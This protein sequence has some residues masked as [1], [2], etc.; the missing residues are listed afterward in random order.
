MIY[1]PNEGKIISNCRVINEISQI[2]YHLRNLFILRRRISK[3]AP[4]NEMIQNENELRVI[5]KHKIHNCG[6]IFIRRVFIK[7]PIEANESNKN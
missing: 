7:S 3:R 1:T 2:T 5:R 6:S 4:F